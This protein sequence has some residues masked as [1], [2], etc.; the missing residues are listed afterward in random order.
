MAKGDLADMANA[1]VDGGI[2]LSRLF[3]DREVL[4]RQVLLYRELVRAA[5]LPPAVPAPL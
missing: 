3:E 2:I 5:F 4:P 1:L